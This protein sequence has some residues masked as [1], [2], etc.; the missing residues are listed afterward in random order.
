MDH[1][2][3][4]HTHSTFC[5]GHD[6]PQEMVEEAIR[7]GFS[8]LGFS[9]HS[10]MSFSPSHSMSLAG[11]ED[12]RREVR[13]LSALYRDRLEIFCGLEVELFSEVDTAGYDYLIGSA[14]YFHIDGEYVGFDRS[15]SCVRDVITRYFGGDSMR[16]AKAYYELLSTLPAHGAFDI[17]GHFDLVAKHAEAPALLDASSPFYL[18]YAYDAIDA[19]RGRIPFFEVNT[20]GI[21]RG[22]RKT[23][24]PSAPIVKRLLEAGF[25][26]V[27]SS[28][29]HDKAHL[30]SA[31]SEAAALLLACGAKERYILT[32]D[33]FTAVPV[34]GGE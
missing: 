28:D 12:Y 14:H 7:R 17:L 20:G 2:Q 26:P 23:P 1:L 3:N 29:C 9:G 31:F 15:E 6:T 32:R 30:D 33:G 5:D 19:L 10:Y 25:L 4:L 34:E 21:S 16:Y 22:Y 13:R 8:S 24:Y 18:R 27:I 11:T